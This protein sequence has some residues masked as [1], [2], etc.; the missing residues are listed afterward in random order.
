MEKGL[1]DMLSIAYD[2]RGDS[3]SMQSDWGFGCLIE[4]FSETVLFDTGA[5]GNILL[6]NVRC[7]NV[8]PDDIDVIVLSHDHWDHTGGLEEV[9]ELN[10]NVTVYMPEVFPADLKE[11][12][13]GAGAELIETAA[14]TTIC[15]RI[16]TTPV[17]EGRRPEQGLTVSR[18]RNQFLI[19]G[20][21]H[22]GIAEMVES[23]DGPVDGCLGGFHLKDA[24]PDAVQNTIQRLK[25]LGVQRV[26][27]C[28][29]SGEKARDMMRQQ[30][31]DGFMPVVVGRWFT[32]RD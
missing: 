11:S 3:G 5:D 13:R 14:G 2:N 18:G 1:S 19:T 28:H 26:G 6:H 4:G 24:A 16:S 23:V 31:G 17:L 29:C 27:P 12:V 15:R 10:P 8:E 7:L 20:C 22:P 9:L 32:F 30:F 21:A 25:R